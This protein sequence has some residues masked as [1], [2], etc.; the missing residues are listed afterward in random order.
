MN[1][2]KFLG[3]LTANPELKYTNDGKPVCKFSMAVNRNYKGSDG[4][5]P[6]DFINFVAWGKTGE[7]VAKY[8]KKG[9]RL[10][11]SGS[12][13]VRKYQ[14]NDG[15]NRTLVEINVQNIDFVEKF[16]NSQQQEQKPQA[17]QDTRT[18]AQAESGDYQDIDFEDV[19]F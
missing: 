12:H 2:C 13:Q 19:P 10:I 14:A 7:V 4:K 15:T 17:Q 1:D 9:H 18:Q 5:Y 16:D 11:V 3:R 6:V 8:V